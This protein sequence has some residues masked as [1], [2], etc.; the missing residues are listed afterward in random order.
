MAVKESQGR[1]CL[2]PTELDASGSVL[3]APSTTQTLARF[4]RPRLNSLG[5]KYSYPL[6]ESSLSADR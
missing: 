2:Y 1:D 6:R 4:M 5:C 3:L